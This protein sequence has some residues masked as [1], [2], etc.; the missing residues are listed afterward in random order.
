MSKKKT[1]NANIQTA[2]YE[3]SRKTVPFLKLLKL[4]YD[5]RFYDEVLE[6]GKKVEIIV[7]AQ[8]GSS[9]H[10]KLKSAVMEYVLF[11][12]SGDMGTARQMRQR[13]Y[14]YPSENFDEFLSTFAL[15][16]LPD[17]MIVRRPSLF[18]INRYF[19]IDLDEDTSF[20]QEEMEI[21][22]QWHPPLTDIN[23]YFS[24]AYT[25]Y[26]NAISFLN[27][28][29]GAEK[30]IGEI[31]EKMEVAMDR[32]IL[33]NP[34][35]EV[36]NFTKLARYMFSEGGNNRANHRHVFYY[37]NALTG[38]R[39]E[40]EHRFRSAKIEYQERQPSGKHGK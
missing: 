38:L 40:C 30:K 31:M 9:L 20:P 12:V 16:G 13:F 21:A 19:R 26:D 36:L 5:D 35:D 32:Y 18:F 24:N 6:T 23:D 11:I 37:F 29:R 39:A 3:V 15:K 4:T 25:F 34:N 1:N 17:D 14:Y 27:L 22:L 8:A 2:K 33:N 7:E 28:L 10:H